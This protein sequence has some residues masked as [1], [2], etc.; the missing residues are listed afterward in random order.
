MMAKHCTVCGNEVSADAHFCGYCGVA[1]ENDPTLKNKNENL[2]LTNPRAQSRFLAILSIALIALVL[3]VYLFRNAAPAQ[4]ETPDAR[5]ESPRIAG[6]WVG[7]A[8]K[9]D[10]LAYY[11]AVELYMDDGEVRGTAIT[12]AQDGT[13]SA[14]A[15]IIG[16]YTNGRLNFVEYGGGE[17]GEWED[18]NMC[19]WEFDLELVKVDGEDTLSGTFEAVD[20]DSSGTIE[21]RRPE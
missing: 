3:G 16:S 6:S 21:L 13:G 14:D 15:E 8:L 5:I 10:G 9:D 7:M 18:S 2:A 12:E 11:Y 4:P 20:C 1:L 19:F 17:S